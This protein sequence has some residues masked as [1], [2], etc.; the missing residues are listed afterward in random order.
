MNLKSYRYIFKVQYLGFRYSGW[1]RQPG[2]R[3]IEGMLLKTLKF[4][5]PNTAV[6]I[7][8][9]GRTD[10]K[11]SAA[12]AAF[13]LF[14]GVEIINTQDFINFLLP[15]NYIRRIKI[16]LSMNA[17]DRF[18]P[19]ASTIDNFFNGNSDAGPFV[20]RRSSFCKREISGYY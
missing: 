8:G 2:Q 16:K 3:T 18:N 11:V 15:F 17:I 1:Q 10:A 9:A 14:T 19:F 7:L 4:I 13:E 12:D 6:K 20:L 5:L